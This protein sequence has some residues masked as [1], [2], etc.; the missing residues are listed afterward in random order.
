MATHYVITRTTRNRNT[1]PLICVY[2]DKQKALNVYDNLDRVLH[3]Y[4]KLIETSNDIT[5]QRI[6]KSEYFCFESRTWKDTATLYE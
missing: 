4:Y 1:N 3:Y 2:H 6:I 5:N